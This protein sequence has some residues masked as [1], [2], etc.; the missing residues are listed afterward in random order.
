MPGRTASNE[1]SASQERLPNYLSPSDVLSNGSE[2]YSPRGRTLA[3][4]GAHRDQI[5]RDTTPP[6][7]RTYPESLGSNVETVQVRYTSR[8]LT[9][10][11]EPYG[12]IHDERD[13]PLVLDSSAEVPAFEKSVSFLLHRSSTGESGT[14]SE[15]DLSIPL[16]RFDG[17]RDTFA[18]LRL[19]QLSHL[20]IPHPPGPQLAREIPIWLCQALLPYLDFDTY[21]SLRLS[22]RSWS[23]MFTLISPLSFPSVYYLPAE[24]LEQVFRNLDPWSFDSARHTCRNWLLASLEKS[25]LK[26]MLE[27]GGWWG[28]SLADREVVE[29]VIGVDRQNVDDGEIWM[30][31]RRLATECSLGRSDWERNGTRTRASTDADTDAKNEAQSQYS[32]SRRLHPP[33]HLISQTDFSN[34]ELEH[35]PGDGFPIPTLFAVSICSAYLLVATGATIHVYHLQHS[36]RTPTIDTHMRPLTTLTCPG[37]VLALSMDTSRNSFAIVALL[38]GRRGMVFDFDPYWEIPSPETADVFP[39]DGLEPK[40]ASPRETYQ[41]SHSSETCVGEAEDGRRVMDVQFVPSGAHG[42]GGGAGGTVAFESE[43]YSLVFVPTTI[44]SGPS[45]REPSTTSS[46]PRSLFPSSDTIHEYSRVI[47]RHSQPQLQ[48][49]TKT[50]IYHNLCSNISPPLSVAI[51]PSRRCVAFGCSTG[52]EL[53][54]VDALTGRDLNRWFALDGGHDY[55]YFMPVKNDGGRAAS[56]DE[57]GSEDEIT[58]GGKKLRLISSSAHPALKAYRRR[59]TFSED[60]DVPEDS[61]VGGYSDR[62]AARGPDHYRAIPLSDGIHILFTDPDSGCLCL[63]INAGD[64]GM[65][66]TKLVKRVILLGPN[67]EIEGECDEGLGKE[68][69]KHVLLPSVY[70]AGKDLKWGVRVAVAFGDRVW[71]FCVPPDLLLSDDEDRPRGK[72]REKKAWEATYPLW[73]VDDRN[74]LLDQKNPF[75]IRG[76]EFARVEAGVVDLAVDSRFGSVGV[77]VV[78]GDKMVW[79]WNIVDGYD[80]EVSCRNVN[81]DGS[82]ALLKDGDGDV[83]MR[84]A[85]SSLRWDDF[86]AVDFGGARNGDGD[87]DGDG[88][89]ERRAVN[90]YL[91]GWASG[92]RTMAAGTPRFV[93]EGYSSD[94]DRVLRFGGGGFDGHGDVVG[95]SDVLG[96]MDEIQEPGFLGKHLGFGLLFEV[97]Q[98]S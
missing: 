9:S 62:G 52:I 80:R 88:L 23:A 26:D 81:V 73:H 4:H 69:S 58:G 30:M 87:T 79:A 98:Y 74:V 54:W 34:L 63:G 94:H 22:C 92:A 50:K 76:I 8:D 96:E 95:D 90:P 6:R 2:E 19:A 37:M 86:Q 97:V 16:T 70:A 1:S 36:Q 42:E 65:G 66:G 68:T 17:H 21:L 20:H 38:E 15:L 28:G 48:P 55:L 11:P 72:N 57:K 49:Q 44:V 84:E 7:S 71:L 40:N 45:S 18:L 46:S 32:S 78:G 67:D 83:M 27:R 35:C 33:L 12:T 5:S 53:H 3:R 85:P 93:D 89:V 31:S 10:E 24:I 43:T 77:W 13:F 39:S 14:E 47:W 59:T 60:R 64:H 56:E 51:C 29:N 82:I 75:I 91:D 41:V 25:L 61:T